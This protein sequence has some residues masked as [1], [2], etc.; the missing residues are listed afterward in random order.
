MR[1]PAPVSRN[2]GIQKQKSPCVSM[3][4]AIRGLPEKSGRQMRKRPAKTPGA[5]EKLIARW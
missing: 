1:A 3:R 5:F 4:R 2:T